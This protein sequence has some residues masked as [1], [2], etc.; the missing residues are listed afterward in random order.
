MMENIVPNIDGM[1]VW[2]IVGLAAIVVIGFFIKGP[3]K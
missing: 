2:W 3:K 1:S